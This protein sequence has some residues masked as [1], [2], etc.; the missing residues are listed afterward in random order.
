MVATDK[1]LFD[2]A[3][4]DLMAPLTVTLQEHQSLREA[5]QELVRAKVHG[6]PVVDSQGRCVGVLSV[7]DLA[8]WA[9]RSTDSGDKA[10]T[11]AVSDH[12]GASAGDPEVFGEWQMVDLESLPVDNVRQFMTPGTVTV[13]L[14]ARVGELARAMTRAGVH[15]VIVVNPADRPVGIVSATDLI[16]ALA[17]AGDGQGNPI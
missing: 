4:A 13:G 12:G 5:A 11:S 3:A 17:A 10:R 9:V 6:A 1:P 8:H 2:L 7:T 14:P 16:A 15:R